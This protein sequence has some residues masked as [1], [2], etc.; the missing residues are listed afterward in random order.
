MP[1]HGGIVLAAVIVVNHV[2]L[3]GPMLSEI[4]KRSTE[5]H[6]WNRRRSAFVSPSYPC[7]PLQLLVHGVPGKEM[8]CF[9]ASKSIAPLPTL[10]PP[11]T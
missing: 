8:G 9:K 10:P 1:A 7:L 3:P 2:M 11:G 6:A 4:L 5:K